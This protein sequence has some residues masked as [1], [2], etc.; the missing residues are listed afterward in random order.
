MILRIHLNRQRSL[1]TMLVLLCMVASGCV[2][3]AWNRAVEEDTPAAYYRFLRDHDDSKHAAEARERLEYHK[4]VANPS[5]E[6][7]ETFR[8]K[9]P[10]SPL[11]AGLMPSLEQPAFDFARARGTSL[12]YRDFL[13]EF[14]SG[15][16]AARAIGNATYLE[17]NAFSGDPARLADFGNL[18]PESDFAAEALRTAETVAARRGAADGRLGLRFILDPALPEVRRVRQTLQD[19]IAELAMR[20]GVKLVVLPDASSTGPSKSGPDIVLEVSHREEAVTG[21]AAGGLARPAVLGVTRLVLRDEASDSVIAERSFEIRVDDKA[22]VPGTSVLFSAAAP[23][24]WEQF[25]VPLASWNNDRAVRPPLALGPPVVDVAGF[26][27]RSVVLYEDGD[28]DLFDLADPSKP[29]KLAGYERGEDYKKW[30]GVRVVG[31]RIAIFGEEGLELVRF[32]QGRPVRERTWSRGE[33]GRVLGLAAVGHE[34]VIVGAKGMQVIDPEKG[35]IRRAMRRVLQGIGAAGNAL[36]FADGESIYVSNLEL[37]VDERVIAQLKLGKTF[38]PKHVRVIDHTAIVTGPG[39]ALVIDVAVA[40]RPRVV[41]KLFSLEIGEVFDATRI[42]GRIYLV[43]QRGLQVLNRSLDGVEET[44]DVG[45]RTRVSAMGRHL[46]TADG[47]G[48]QVVDMSPWAER[49]LPAA[50]V[51]QASGAAGDR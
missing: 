4:L 31:E 1:R 44:V 45:A 5:L 41:G 48:L 17:E 23:R 22:H 51:P 24:Y 47:A 36:I 6:G 9:H 2:G 27:D 38:G 10:S 8:K 26:G 11:L 18:H 25:F 50:P 29:V 34:L 40:E 20:A 42:D 14:P 28:L 13:T 21:A 7:F 32:D 46:V 16:L 49:S 39:G 35:T 3:S 12:A 43:G 37:L 19:R 30:T 33:I 15:K